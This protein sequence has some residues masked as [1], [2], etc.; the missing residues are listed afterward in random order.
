M[1]AEKYNPNEHYALVEAWAEARGFADRLTPDSVSPFGAV[2]SDE[3][4]PAMVG[5]CYFAIGCSVCFFERLLSRPGL[6]LAAAREAGREVFRFLRNMAAI[7]NYRDGYAHLDHR[8]L[9][10]ELVKLGFT[11][12][13]EGVLMHKSL[14][15][16]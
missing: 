9:E 6:S 11:T 7:N 2:V 13:V 3:E 12:H 10:G 8:S 5:F 16:S 14:Q 15:P 4:G 1:K